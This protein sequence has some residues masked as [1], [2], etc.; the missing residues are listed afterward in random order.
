MG[1]WTGELRRRR[2]GGG[3]G[4]G[5]KRNEKGEGEGADMS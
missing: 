3:L 1:R 2:E 4:G 5:E